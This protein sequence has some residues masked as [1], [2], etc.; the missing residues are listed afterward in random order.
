M[1]LFVALDIDDGIR[2]RLARFL[3][4]VRGFSPDARWARPESLH[5][6]LKFIGEKSEEE[7]E[8]IKRA[9]E[10]IVADSF[11]MNFRGYGFFPGARAPRVFWV[12]IEAGP[13]L[14]S[15]A[16]MVDER[17]AIARHPERGA[18]FHSASHAGAGWKRLGLAAQAGRRPP[19][20][21][22]SA[23]AGETGGPACTRV[24]YHD[25]PRVFS[26]PESAFTRRLKV[27]EAGR[28]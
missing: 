16:A 4:G 26:L 22:L 15:L 19:E 7:M 1:R 9:L 3:D 11:E 5:V 12:G 20:P 14:C 21:E 24:W 23:V 2:G 18:C 25:D 10:T 6:T 28:I 17:L 13:K 27:H 8:K